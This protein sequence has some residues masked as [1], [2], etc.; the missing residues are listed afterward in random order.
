M[1][2]LE[3]LGIAAL[4]R[5]VVC[6][7]ETSGVVTPS[8][9]IGERLMCAI[10]AARNYRRCSSCLQ[11]RSCTIRS[12]KGFVAPTHRTGGR[13]VTPTQQEVLVEARSL[14]VTH[15]LALLGRFV[16]LPALCPC[17]AKSRAIA[18]AIVIARP[19]LLAGFSFAGIRRGGPS[20][21]EA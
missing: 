13:V 9:G 21:Q 8:F 4:R 10:V 1:S 12:C 17:A 19:E 18:R 7:A 20:R 5:T 2:R 16:I 3:F 14:A 11:E 6:S 15:I